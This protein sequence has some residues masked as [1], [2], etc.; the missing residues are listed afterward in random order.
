MTLSLEGGGPLDAQLPALRHRAAP[1][2]CGGGGGL[3]PE[4]AQT[5]LLAAPT[6]RAPRAQAPQPLPAGTQGSMRLRELTSRRGAW[7]SE[8]R[9]WLPGP[10]WAGG[11]L[12]VLGAGG[13]LVRPLAPGTQQACLTADRKAEA[14]SSRQTVALPQNRTDTKLFLPKGQ[15]YGAWSALNTPVAWDIRGL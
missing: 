1:G 14:A 3:P 4:K 10:V 12:R 2:R 8:Q 7:P 6:G 11:L 13:F 5:Q 9:G 15:K